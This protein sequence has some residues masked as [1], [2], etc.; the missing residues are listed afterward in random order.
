MHTYMQ[1]WPESY[2][3]FAFPRLVSTTITNLTIDNLEKD[4]VYSTAVIP[5]EDLAKKK[6]DQGGTWNSW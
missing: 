3:E 1:N 4:M 5:K 6:Y 2:L